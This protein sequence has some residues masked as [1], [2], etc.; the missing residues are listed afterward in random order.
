MSTRTMAAAVLLAL[1]PLIRPPV[2]RGPRVE[3]ADL[4]MVAPRAGTLSAARV[5]VA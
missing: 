4:Y 2:P 1:V 5:L 3:R